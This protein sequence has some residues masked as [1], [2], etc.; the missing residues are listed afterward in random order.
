[1][2]VPEAPYTAR[3]EYSVVASVARVAWPRP[4]RPRLPVPARGRDR[5]AGRPRAIAGTGRSAVLNGPRPLE[6]GAT[7]RPRSRA[8]AAPRRATRGSVAEACPRP[9]RR[10]EAATP[11]RGRGQAAW[12]IRRPRPVD[13]VVPVH[14]RADPPITSNS[15]ATSARISAD[16]RRSSSAASSSPI[17]LGSRSAGSDSAH[18][19]DRHSRMFAQVKPG[20]A[21]P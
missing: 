5:T 17:R 7:A 6:A 18:R 3:P 9:G 2:S 16:P 15:P 21:V 13:R 10:V 4:T 8:H 1:M 12:E 11:R 19:R 14:D 20:A